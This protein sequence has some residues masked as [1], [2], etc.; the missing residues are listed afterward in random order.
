M[1]APS[2]VSEAHSRGD[3]LGSAA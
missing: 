3:W 1:K 2:T